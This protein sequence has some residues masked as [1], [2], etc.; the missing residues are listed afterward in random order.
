MAHKNQKKYNFIVI[1]AAILALLFIG[2]LFLPYFRV[3]NDQTKQ[4]SYSI[5]GT[6]I[7]LG[8]SSNGAVIK[9]S[10]VILVGQIIGSFG[11]LL[12]LLFMIMYLIKKDHKPIMYLFLGLSVLCIA[13]QIATILLSGPIYQ[14]VNE[15]KN[16]TLIYS[17]WY[18]FTLVI[19][20]I[21]F[22]L[23][24]F[25]IFYASFSDFKSK[26]VSHVEKKDIT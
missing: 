25:I 5:R 16:K 10:N 22:L 12:T 2:F 6:T 24:L 15:I 4:L 13:F 14:S 21:S 8:S 20:I 23:N 3:Y 17:V 26:N 11:G 7:A 1:I 9:G 18:Y 19:S